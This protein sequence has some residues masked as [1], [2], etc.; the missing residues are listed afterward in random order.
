MELRFKLKDLEG[1][2][3]NYYE[4]QTRNRSVTSVKVDTYHDSG[5][6][7]CRSGG[8]SVTIKVKGT[9]NVGSMSADFEEVVSTER[10]RAIMVKYLQENEPSLEV[11]DVKFDA[12][13]SAI[14]EGSGMGERTVDK[15]YNKGLVVTVK[16][17]DI[18]AV[19]P[20]A[21]QPKPFE[22]R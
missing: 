21:V 20:P 8:T 18:N 14:T 15:T 11:T 13:V 17:R 2:V 22:S 10:L 6:G 7:P 19:V 16:E 9:T 12:G 4:A 5:D 3:K 1:V